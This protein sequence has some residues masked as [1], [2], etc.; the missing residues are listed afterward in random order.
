[1]RITLT[2]TLTLIYAY[3][4]IY[5]PI[6]HLQ[7]DFFHN[8]E[9]ADINK[10][11]VRAHKWRSVADPDTR[12]GGQFNMFPSI[13]HLFRRWRGLKSISKLGGVMARSALWIQTWWR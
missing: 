11:R 1:M 4:I 12:L 8:I 6:T 13:S 2:L 7:E 9:M 10:M 3:N 5:R